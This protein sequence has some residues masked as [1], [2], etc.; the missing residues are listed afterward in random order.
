VHNELEKHQ[1]IKM[2]LQKNN[3]P[4]S[5]INSLI[6]RYKIKN[7]MTTTPQLTMSTTSALTT[8]TTEDT[9]TVTTSTNTI[10]EENTITPL[11]NLKYRSIPYIKGLSEKTKKL[12]QQNN[13][14]LTITFRNN[15]N[16]SI[17][18]R[19]KDKNDIWSKTNIQFLVEL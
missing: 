15:F 3:Y 19:I 8:S 4:K 16:N 9:A 10:T 7:T 1:K 14:D 11:T 2:I 13:S 5:L 18:S 12:L 17:F 6:K